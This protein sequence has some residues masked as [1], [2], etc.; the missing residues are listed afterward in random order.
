MKESIP[1]DILI[2]FLPIFYC[3]FSGINFKTSS[4]ITDKMKTNRLYLRL[5]QI[6]SEDEEGNQDLPLI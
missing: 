4:A 6:Y 2:Y 5:P 1:L 3:N